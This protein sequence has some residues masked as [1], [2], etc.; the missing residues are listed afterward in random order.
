M[1]ASLRAS[2]AYKPVFMLLQ[3]IPIFETIYRLIWDFK[4][5]FAAK[6]A[7]VLVTWLI[8]AKQLLNREVDS[9][10]SGIERDLDAVIHVLSNIE[11]NHYAINSQGS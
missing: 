8:S 5:M 9:F 6:D 4:A 2:T 7:T 11:K 1:F 10:I 3:D